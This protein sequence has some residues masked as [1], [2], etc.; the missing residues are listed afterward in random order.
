[1]L[2]LIILVLIQSVL[3]VGAQSFLKI[4]VEIFGK[5]SWS[6]SFFKQAFTTWQFPVSGI[7]ALSS[8]VLWMYVL[9]KFPFSQAYPMLSISYIAGLVTSV[10]VFHEAVPATRWIG[11]AIIIAG[12][13]LV[14]K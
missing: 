12:C 9:K 1:M 14:A 2:E 6:W 4:S 7:F 8:V 3:L 10:I 5:F 13:I 11:V